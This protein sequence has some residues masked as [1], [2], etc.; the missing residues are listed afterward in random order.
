MSGFRYPI[1]L[2]VEGQRCVV[3]GGGVV[4]EH[5]VHGLLAAGAD[6]VVVAA[7]P[8]GGLESLAGEGSV[9]LVRRAYADGDLEG[10]RLAIAATDEAAVNAA[11]Y[12]EGDR[13]RVLVNSVDDVEHCHFAVPSVVRRGALTLTVATGGQAP[14][15]AKK[16]R[17]ALEAEFGPEYA[18]VVALV[19]EVR[20]Q[21]RAQRAGLG[22]DTWAQRWE[23][24]LD[25]EVVALVREGHIEAARRRLLDALTGDPRDF[26]NGRVAP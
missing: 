7:E 3:V 20:Q 22:F 8:S 2:E 13:R 11:V 25:D 9:T 1:S 21:A 10:A 19:G 12:A 26:V 16:L 5:K 14:A 17:R 6:V 18:A 15:L 23:E 24:A 4:A